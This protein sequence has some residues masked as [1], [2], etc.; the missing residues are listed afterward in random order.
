MGA[1]GPIET[2]HYSYLRQ[3]TKDQRFSGVCLAS[4]SSA[5]A[6]AESNPIIFPGNRIFGKNSSRA[7]N[8]RAKRVRGAERI[9]SLFRAQR[10][11]S[12]KLCD[13][14]RSEKTFSN[15]GLRKPFQK[16]LTTTPAFLILN[17][18]KARK[19]RSTR[20]PMGQREETVGASLS[21]VRGRSPRSCLSEHS[22]TGRDFPLQKP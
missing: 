2:D 1:G 19:G 7:A 16:T 8:V 21:P 11:G 4:Q 20:S 6:E 14:L 10:S 3:S 5:S 15:A 9:P 13:K 22:R 12:E 18:L 17:K